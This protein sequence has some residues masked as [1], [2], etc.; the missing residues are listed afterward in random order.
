[1]MQNYYSGTNIVSKAKKKENEKN[2]G[3]QISSIS[4]AIPNIGHVNL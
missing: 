4:L 2:V 1:M 3:N